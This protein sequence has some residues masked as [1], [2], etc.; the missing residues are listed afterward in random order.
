VKI[1]DLE[2][3]WKGL[4]ESVVP[5]VSQAL[6]FVAGYWTRSQGGGNGMGMIVF[7]SQEAAEAATE[8]IRA[9]TTD[10]VTVE[11]VEVREVVEHA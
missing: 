9:G 2:T 4:Q 3:A 8:P 10:G 1:E 5:A 7:E 11:D 6:G